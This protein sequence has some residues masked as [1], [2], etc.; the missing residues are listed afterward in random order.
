[1]KVE[2]VLVS[3]LCALLA[4]CFGYYEG[5][6]SASEFFGQ[7]SVVCAYGGAPLNGASP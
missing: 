3:G 7:Q 2:F 6:V 5:N 4:F 1:M